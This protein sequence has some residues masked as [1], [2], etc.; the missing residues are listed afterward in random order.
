M[1]TFKDVTVEKSGNVI[2]KDIS[3]ELGDHRLGIIGRNGSGKSTLARLINGLEKPSS[4]SVFVGGAQDIKALRRKVGFV[5]QNPDNQIVYPIVNEDLEFGL[6]NLKLPAIERRR[7]IADILT[8]FEITHLADRFTH[9]LSGGEKQLIA[10][11]GVLVMEP[12]IIVFDEPTTL[13]DL[14][15]TRRFMAAVNTL[16]QQVIMVTH[17]LDLIRDFDRTLL[18][19]NGEIS[20]DG[21]PA[22]IIARYCEDQP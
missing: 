6:K 3:V 2:L 17:N 8:R 16:S 5:F 10:L 21:K 22:D 15:N 18:I 13:L 1:I 20:A 4:G 7:R 11:A 12:E 9:E 14:W 19:D